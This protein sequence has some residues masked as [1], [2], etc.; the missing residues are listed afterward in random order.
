MAKF[1]IVRSLLAFYAI[2][3]QSII[4]LDAFFCDFANPDGLL[5]GNALS[6]CHMDVDLL[7]TGTVVCPRQVNGIEYVWHPQ[8]AV[9]D[10]TLNVYVSDDG[11]LRSVAFSDVVVTE[12]PLTFVFLDSMRKTTEMFFEFPIHDI[13]AITANRLIFICGPQD[14]VLSAALQSILGGL[15]SANQTQEFPWTTATPL[16]QEISK[17]G[18]G[19]GAVFLNRD[20]RHLPLQGCG[21]RPSPLFALDNEVTVDPITGTRSCVA[22]PMSLSRIGFVCDGRLE[23]SDC[24]KSLLDNNGGVVTVPPPRYYRSFHFN[25]PWVVANYYHELALP[26]VNGECRCV[27]SETGQVKAKI[28]IRSKTEYIC[29]ISS[30]IERNR[31]SPI[32]GPWCSVVLHPG[33]TLTIRFP[34]I[35]V[36]ANSDEDPSQ[37]P[38]TYEYEA[39]FLPKDLATLRQLNRYYDFDIYDEVSYHKILA[40]DAL[41]LDVSQMY[42]G[43]IKLKYHLDKPLSSQRR[44]A[45]FIYHLTLT[46]KDESVQDRLRAVVNVSFAFTHRYK[47]IGCDRGTHSVFDTDMSKKYCSTKQMGNGVGNT[48][49]CIYDKSIVDSHGGIRCGDNED[50]LPGNCE[51][52][53]YDLHSNSIIPFPSALRNVTPYSIRGF[54]AL[55]MEYQT[56]PS[57]YACICVDQRGYEKSRLISEYNFTEYRCYNVR[58]EE[59]IQTSLPNLSLPW[60]DVGLSNAGSPSPK[61]LVLHYI[62]QKNITI[63]VG[64]EFNMV[65]EMDPSAIPYSAMLNKN[66]RNV[67]LTTTWLPKRPEEFYYTVIH[68]PHGP[69]LIRRTYRESFATTPGG[70]EIV[71]HEESVKPEYKK[72]TITSRRSAIL[73]SKDRF[74]KKHVPMTFVCGKAPKETDVSI[75]TRKSSARSGSSARYTWHMVQVNVETTDP[76]MQGCGVTDESDELFKPDTPPLYDSDGQPQFGCKIDIQAANE[77]AFYCPAPYVL[78]PP[79]CFSQV[80]VDGEVRNLSELSNS[81]VSSLSNHFVILSF[82]GSLVGTGETLGQ[83]P[84]LE[85]RCVTTKGV[86]LSTI[87]IENYYSK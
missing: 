50:L 84:P 27:D 1:S 45:S 78:D 51:S 8:P 9:G 11:K 44:D 37:Q 30:M 59:D 42:R 72:L 68:T 38:S 61:P 52:A 85:C 70:L 5:S 75:I 57:S 76:Y 81:L 47:M 53:V 25:Q 79:N 55:E 46:S 58:R 60:S 56:S 18:K 2:A 43:E 7:G 77:A 16:V 3:L 34:I 29:D 86:I 35:G 63:Q 26:P 28:E 74:Y 19:L 17:I 80:L 31:A 71:Y 49:E 83:T 48:Y 73:I 65:C 14:L 54:K 6:S 20:R 41:E 4:C 69:E 40:G 24:T 62:P 33:S 15:K 82:D 87:Q 21:S 67:D 64:T 32:S 12:E 13:Y 22:N 36:D 23:P 10:E 39:E 66:A